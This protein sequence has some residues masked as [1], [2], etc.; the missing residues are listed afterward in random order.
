MH[1]VCSSPAREIQHAVEELHPAVLVMGTISRTGLPGLLVG[2]TAERV[3]P[4][5][6]CSLLSIK[7]ETFDSPLK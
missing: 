6:D 7:P 1:I 3:L 2:H 4:D 5:L